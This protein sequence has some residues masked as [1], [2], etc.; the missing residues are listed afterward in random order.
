MFVVSSAALLL[1]HL[2]PGDPFSGLGTHPEYAEAERAR[3][4]LDRPFLRT[5]R[6]VAGAGPRGWT[7]ANRLAFERPVLQLLAERVPRTLLLGVS[8][9]LLAIGARYSARGRAWA[10]RPTAGGRG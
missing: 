6:A 3:L 10:R 7:S 1:V 4:G 8:A 2:A 9:L 5:V